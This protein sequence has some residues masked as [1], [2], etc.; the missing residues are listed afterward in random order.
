MFASG[1][2]SRLGR[3][4]GEQTVLGV[5]YPAPTGEAVSLL[6]QDCELHRELQH[7]L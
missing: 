1:G 3:G 2:V 6:H 5:P 7:L 4:Q